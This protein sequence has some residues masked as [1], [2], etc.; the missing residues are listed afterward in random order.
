MK[1]LVMCVICVFLL[2]GCGSYY[3][4][5]DPASKNVYYTTDIEETKGGAIKFKDAKSGSDVTLQSSE[6][7]EIGS[8]EF[9]KATVPA[10]K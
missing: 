8:E 4:V 5:T 1:R 2:V 7:K 3:K 6:I 10:K 9:E